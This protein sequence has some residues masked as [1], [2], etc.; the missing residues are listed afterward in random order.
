[1]IKNNRNTTI[2]VAKGIGI[3]L[4]VL[5][6]TIGDVT[7]LSN[8]IIL[9]FH[10]PLF[11]FISGYFAMNNK[12][13][14]YFSYIK[15]R[16]Y[17]LLLPQITLGL[18]WTL[19]EII[20]MN[21]VLNSIEL[22]EI[23]IIE[24]IIRWWFLL[25]LLWVSII[26]ELLLRL[27]KDRKEMPFIV[28]IISLIIAVIFKEKSKSILYTAVIPT[29]LCFYILGYIC[30]IYRIHI[31]IKDIIR[32]S[33]FILLPILIIIATTNSSILMYENRYGNYTLFLMGS[34]IGIY[35]VI[36]YANNL[37]NNKLLQWCGEN[38][39]IIY[40]MHFPVV[41]CVRR[42]M[43]RLFVGQPEEVIISIGF[44]VVCL[45]LLPIT[46]ICNKYFSF[47]FGKKINIKNTQKLSLQ[48]T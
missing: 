19:Y 37:K 48:N 1:M 33:S 38:S 28:F 12:K 17:S 9:A 31:Y 23:N 27:F 35:L 36:N 2:D 20:I 29:A 7:L 13:G 21:L 42:I 5:G 11:F 39:I 34:I 6:H 8:K 30:N 46:R 26:W 25:V 22:Q 44:I 3:L 15:K 32:D 24:N 45:L 40:V 18:A 43:N 14:T 10:M 16:C 41:Q 4:V 47:M